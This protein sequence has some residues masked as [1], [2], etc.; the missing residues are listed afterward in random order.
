MK[1]L[2]NITLKEY[3]LTW[4]LDAKDIFEVEKLNKLSKTEIFEIKAGNRIRAK[5]YVWI[6]KIN[7]KNIQILP[8]IFWEEQESILKNLIYMLS[9]TKK[10]KVRESDIA[11][12]WKVDDLFEVFIYIYAKELFQLL[13]RDFK[14]NYN[15]IEENS[16][17]L[18]WKLLFGKHIKHNLFDKSKFFIGYEKMDENFLLNIFLNS[19]CEKLLAITKSSINYKLLSKCKFIL[20]DIDTKVF[21]NSKCLDTLNF[22]K[23]NK[24]YKNVFSLWKMLY[25]W[26]SPDFSSNLENNFSLLFDMN[27]LFEEFIVEFMKNNKEQ[28]NPEIS[29]ID[30]QVSNRY[31][32]ENNKFTLKPDIYISYND[33]SNVVIDTK[34]K[35]LDS[36]K[37]NNWVSSQDIYQM[38]IYWMRYFWEYNTNKRKNIILLYPNYDR[39]DYD[40]TLTAEENI[41]IFIRTINM[42]LDLS[43]LKGKSNL[44]NQLKNIILSLK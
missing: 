20:K 32:F 29:T 17:F 7:N 14:K 38:F 36:S 13:K 10:L 22:N 23:Q 26:N 2:K 39:E 21:R 18:K 16:S 33:E 19:T 12:L 44:N 9:Y 1:K 27:L 11:Y 42:N 25:F 8:K 5:Q 3:E 41:N 6:V 24:E 28:I 31:V 43:S 37:T 15:K 40:I 4:E 30:S 34:Y 35:K